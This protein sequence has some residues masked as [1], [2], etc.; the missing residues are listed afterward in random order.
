MFLAGRTVN[1]AYFCDVLR[2]LHE[3]VRRFHPEHWRQENWLLHQDSAPSH[4]SSVTR[5]FVTKSNITVVTFPLYF[6]LFPRLKIKLNER[7]FDTFEVIKAE[8]QS[9]MNTLTEHDFQEAFSK[10]QQL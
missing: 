2:R 7:H 9:V 10:R 6:P 1:A 3:Y 5:E 8:L 4:T